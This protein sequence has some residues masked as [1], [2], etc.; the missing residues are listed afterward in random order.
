MEATPASGSDLVFNNGTFSSPLLLGANFT[1]GTITFSNV[2][3]ALPNNLLVE[4][5]KNNAQTLT[6]NTGI[7]L[8]GGYT[9]TLTVQ[10]FGTGSGSLSIALGGSSGTFAAM[11]VDGTATLTLVPVISGSAGITKS[12]TGTLTIGGPLPTAA[13]P[14]SPTVR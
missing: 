9:S 1:V 2:N 12:G 8:T 7:T 4:N 5:T 10:E 13:I 11:Q 6:I 14:T 3:T